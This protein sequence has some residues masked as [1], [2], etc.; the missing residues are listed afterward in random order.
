MI[1]LIFAVEGLAS[2]N[3][4]QGLCERALRLYAWADAMRDRIGD[5]RP[6]VE[7]ASVE[8]DLEDIRS[9]LDDSAVEIAYETGRSMTLEQAI[10]LALS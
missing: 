3:V 2:L 6:P 1:A 10:E 8:R 4:N 9:Q 5:H 7:R